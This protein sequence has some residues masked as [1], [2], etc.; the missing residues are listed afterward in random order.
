MALQREVAE[1]ILAASPSEREAFEA[2]VR[3]WLVAAIGCDL[4]PP[5]HTSKYTH[6]RNP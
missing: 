5:T 2:K 6:T 1:D 4:Q 3:A